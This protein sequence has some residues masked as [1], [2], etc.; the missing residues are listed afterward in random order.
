MT[1]CAVCGRELV[2]EE[3]H[4]CS[5]CT[6]LQDDFLD[7]C[8]GMRQPVTKENFFWLM[9]RETKKVTRGLMV[10]LW[11]DLEENFF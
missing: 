5:R 2:G 6:D 1:R 9:T 7:W 8:D 10:S 11:D 4:N 3:E